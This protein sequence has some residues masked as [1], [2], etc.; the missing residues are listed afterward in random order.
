M[1]QGL[2]LLLDCFDDFWVAVSADVYSDSCEA[3]DVFFSVSVPDP[4]AAA[5]GYVDGLAG[6]GG[7]DVFGFGFYG[8]H[9]WVS[10]VFFARIIHGEYSSK[11][12]LIMGIFS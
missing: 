12:V 10:R 9:E 8:G 5:A 11:V 1:N 6:V 2:C 7:L 3:V 4:G